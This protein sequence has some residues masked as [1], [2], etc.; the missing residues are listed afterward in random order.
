MKIDLTKSQCE[1]LIDFIE[2]NLLDVIRKDTDIDSLEWVQNILTA[3]TIFHLVIAGGENPPE[4][5]TEAPEELTKEEMCAALDA[6]C[7]GKACIECPLYKLDGN[8]FSYENIERNYHIMKEA[9]LLIR[10]RRNDDAVD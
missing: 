4:V 10:K 7:S 2:L 3:N 8:C 5:A 9:G 1:S 6:V